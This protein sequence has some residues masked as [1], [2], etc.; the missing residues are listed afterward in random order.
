MALHVATLVK[1]H[2]KESSKTPPS[3]HCPQFDWYTVLWVFFYSEAVER[4]PKLKWER[5]KGSECGMMHF[6]GLPK[7]HHE[8]GSNGGQ[9]RGW[10]LNHHH[11]LHHYCPT[12]DISVKYVVW[13]GLSLPNFRSENLLRD[14]CLKEQR[15]CQKCAIHYILATI[16][17]L[18]ICQILGMQQLIKNLASIPMELKFI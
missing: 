18:K 15:K 17:I 14:S 10:F 7:A 6:W 11:H 16:G 9:G 4:W 8:V 12:A 5:W 13:Y 1:E 3:P 2:A